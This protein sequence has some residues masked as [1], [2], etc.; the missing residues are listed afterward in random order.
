MAL[1]KKLFTLNLF[2]CALLASQLAQAD[3]P[4]TNQEWADNAWY[5]GVGAGRANTSIDKDRII[6]S[7]MDNGASSVTFGSNERDTAFKLFMG[8]QMN[9]YFA[10]EAG[11]FDLGKFGFNATTTPPGVINGEVGFRGFNLDL[12][13]QLPLTERFSLLGRVGANYT[14]ADAHFSGNRL[15]ALTDPNPTEKKLNPKVGVGLEYKFTQALAMRGEAERYR[16]NDAVHNRGDVDFYSVSLVYKFGKP[17]YARPVAYVASPVPVMQQDPI[18]VTVAQSPPPPPRPQPVSEKITFSAETLF[19]FDKSVVKPPGK[20]ALDDLL[21]KLQGMNTEVMITVGH[22][23][24][25][26]SDAYNQKLSIRRA[27]AVK[28]YLVSKGI[29]ATR[30]YTEGKG[31]T[32][33][34]ADNKT[35]DGRS[36]NR[37]VTVEVVGSRR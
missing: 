29:D 2:A 24:S 17:A 34:I 5:L 3:E 9:R 15:F 16:V 30:V 35:S 18:P 23:D 36:K 20:Q 33:P 1:P 10:I 12:V 11:Y 8:K 28:A 27:E 7:L 22:T 25:V 32:Q 14:R 37:R 26:G 19:D 6:R 21:N 13:G 4:W 31:E